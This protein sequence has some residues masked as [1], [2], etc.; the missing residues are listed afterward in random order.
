MIRGKI[1]AGIARIIRRKIN[2][3]RRNKIKY[4]FLNIPE[5]LKTGITA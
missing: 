2:L 5:A 1:K 3:K 4:I